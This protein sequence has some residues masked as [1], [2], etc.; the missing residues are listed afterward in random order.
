MTAARPA[1]A[2]QSR[3]YSPG[4]LYFAGETGLELCDL[5]F[6]EIPGAAFFEEQF[7]EFTDARLQ[8]QLHTGSHGLLR[9]ALGFVFSGHSR[10]SR[11][12]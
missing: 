6:G 5:H 7:F 10:H 1:V 8:A 4:S 2:G 9:C 3:F 12:P 11:G